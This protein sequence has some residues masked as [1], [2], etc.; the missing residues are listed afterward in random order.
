MKTG[1]IPAAICLVM[2]I[3]FGWIMDSALADNDVTSSGA[4]D[5]SQST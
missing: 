2:L 1:L 5:I 4:T 3:G